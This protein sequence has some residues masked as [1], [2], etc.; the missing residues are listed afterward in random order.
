M[1]EKRLAQ[2]ADSYD[3]MAAEYTRRLFHELDG[4]PFDREQLD[5]LAER[6]RGR[7][8]VCDMGC[9]PGHIARY[10][11]DRGVA[12]VGVDLSP[13]M[14]ATATRL[15]ADIHFYQGNMLALDVADGAWAGVVAFYSLIHIA[16]DEAVA[17]L[18]ELRR[19]L[20]PG[21]LLLLAF[22]TGGTTLHET[23][24]WGERVDLHFW[25]YDAAEMV[26]Y[27]EAAGYHIEQVIER[28]PYPPEIEYQSRRAYILAVRKEEL[29]T[30][31][32]G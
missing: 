7:G 18:A 8:M 6:L 4:K 11:A 16:P 9:G 13:E 22:H 2:T 26:G 19:V 3:R 23:E 30:D 27:L 32:H 15:N 24:A 25:L 1:E 31:R 10:L 21:G 17:A 14:M 29:A 28:D 12:M 5:R 20:Q